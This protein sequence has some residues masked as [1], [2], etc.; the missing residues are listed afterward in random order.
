VAEIYLVDTGVFLRWF[1]PQNG[2]QHALKVQKQFLDGEVLLE[3][4]DFVRIELAEVLRKKGLLDGRLTLSQFLT[5]ARALD[6]LGVVVHAIDTFCVQRA[7]ELAAKRTLRMFDALIVD[8]A[9]QRGTTLLTA[10][11]KLCK[12]IGSLLPAELLP[13]VIST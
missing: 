8:A 9:L 4:V 10:D 12:A 13:G 2:Y 11:S 6:D 1:V 3:T 7:A 5:A